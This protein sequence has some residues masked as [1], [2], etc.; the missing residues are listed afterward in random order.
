MPV[1]CVGLGS[2]GSLRDARKDAE[3]ALKKMQAQEKIRFEQ[4]KKWV[5]SVGRSHFP[6][7]LLLSY[8]Y[9]FIFSLPALEDACHGTVLTS[10][11][12]ASTAQY[13]HTYRVGATST[14]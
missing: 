7:L 1:C 11:V 3:A 10:C 13:R 6:L 9:L 8:L 5:V 2:L 4:H 14:W 12:K